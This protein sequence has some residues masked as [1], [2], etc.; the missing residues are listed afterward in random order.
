[1]TTNII[2]GCGAQGRVVLEVWRAA[3][4]AATF[5]FLDDNKSLHGTR[6]LGAEVAGGLDTSV[7]GPAVLAIGHNV[8]RLALADRLGERFRWAT[9]VHPSAVVMPSAQVEPGTVVF[10]GAVIGTEARIGAH[11]V[12]NTGVIVEHDA[13][14]GRGA[15]LSP[16]VRSGGRIKV[17]EGA[18]VSTG[19]TLAPRVSV[20]AWSVVGA[21]AVVVRDIPDRA[22]AY[23]VPAR[24]VGPVDDTFDWQRLL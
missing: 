18:F 24:V 2:I 12:I 5:V 14:M 4:P 6:I 16:G 22:L 13:V 19:A 7:D 11:V 9:P 1:V 3:E 10:A 17:G 15:S 21:G 8:K 20:G 23:G